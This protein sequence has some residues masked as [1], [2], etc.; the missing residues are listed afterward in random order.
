MPNLTRPKPAKALLSACKSIWDWNVACRQIIAAN[1][2]DDGL[3]AFPDWWQEKIVDSGFRERLHNQFL[4]TEAFE[5]L[6]AN[7]LFR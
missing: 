5:A 4:K 7:R 2:D 6:R 1:K 3:P